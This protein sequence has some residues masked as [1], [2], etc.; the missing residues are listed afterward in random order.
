MA[1]KGAP[2]KK[3]AAQPK[4]GKSAKKASPGTTKKSSPKSTQRVGPDASK[5]GAKGTKG[6][7]AGRLDHRAV[8]SA[9]YTQKDNGGPRDP[10]SGSVLLT[11]MCEFYPR[12]NPIPITV[13]LCLQGSISGGTEMARHQLSRPT[14]LIH[15]QHAAFS[16][17]W[18]S[19]AIYLDDEVGNPAFWMLE[20]K[21]KEWVLYLRRVTG[22]LASYA[23]AGKDRAFPLQLKRVKTTKEFEWPETISVVAHDHY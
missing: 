1:K 8:K 4:S 3:A 17:C 12:G 10:G 15:A 14:H 13:T 18:F 11:P 20:K 22:E 2:K 9:G 5:K 19:R 21:P 23:V 6:S 7:A 16:C